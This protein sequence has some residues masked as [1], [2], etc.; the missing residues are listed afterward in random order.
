MLEELESLKVSMEMLDDNVLNDIQS[1]TE[2][3]YKKLGKTINFVEKDTEC[4]KTVSDF[5]NLGKGPTHNHLQYDLVDLYDIEYPE[6]AFDNNPFFNSKN[7]GVKH[8][9]FHGSR[10]SN[11]AGILSQGLRIAP[12]HVPVHGYMFGKGIYLADIPSK[13]AQ[14]CSPELSD[15]YGILLMCEAHIG[16]TH[17][18]DYSDYTAPEKMQQSQKDSV[19][20][21]GR[22]GPLPGNEIMYDGSILKMGPVSDQTP[23]GKYLIYNEYIVYNTQQVKM[24]YLALVKFK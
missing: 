6:N 1:A 22:L 9:L 18:L 7:K 14:Y 2:N 20:G 8:L 23:P 10:V 16:K 11:F 19:K 5:I 4:F 21:K 13:S 3:D 17:D 15:K 12:P 24:K